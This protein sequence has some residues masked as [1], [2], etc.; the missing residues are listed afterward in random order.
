MQSTCLTY[1][2]NGTGIKKNTLISGGTVGGLLAAFL[3]QD[4]FK[5]VASVI[6][7]DLTTAQK[8]MLCNSVRVSVF[9]FSVLTALVHF[10]VNLM[11]T[12]N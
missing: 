10:T 7:N 4:K 9:V 1:D 8:Q 2:T 6:M 5:S 11:T 12:E 3:G